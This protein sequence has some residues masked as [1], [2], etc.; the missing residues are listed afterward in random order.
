LRTQLRWHGWPLLVL[1]A[2]TLLALGLTLLLPERVLSAPTGDVAA[3]FLYSRAFGFGEMAQGKLPLW[4]PYLFGGVPF[5]GDFQS[6]LLYPP[7]LT[8]LLLPVGLAISW[9]LAIHLFWMGVSVY[10]WACAGRGLSRR[11]GLVAGIAAM[12]CFPFFLHLHAGHLSNICTMAWAPWIFLAV[13]RWFLSRQWRWVI[14]GAAAA[15]L[16]IYAGHPQYAYYTAIMAG[17]Y[18]LI[19]WPWHR[20]FWSFA[21][22]LLALYPLA[23]LLSAAQLLPGLEATAESIRAMDL[24]VSFARSFSFPPENIFTL[25]TPWLWGGLESAFPYAGRW[26][27]WEMNLFGGLGIFLLALAGLGV[28]SGPL[29][30]SVF[31]GEPAS[32]LGKGSIFASCGIKLAVCWVFALLLALGSNTPL[33]DLLVSLVPGFDAIRGISKFVFFCGLFLALLAGFGAQRLLDRPAAPRVVWV[34]L[35]LALLLGLAS[36]W[37]QTPSFHQMVE[38]WVA[39]WTEEDALRTFF[40]GD[41]TEALLSAVTTTLPRAALALSLWCAGFWLTGLHPR[42]LLLFLL[43][44]CGEIFWAARG[45]VVS[46]P[47]QMQNILTLRESLRRIPGDFRIVNSFD[48]NMAIALQREGIWGQE[49]SVLWRYD[50]LVRTVQRLPVGDPSQPFY[51]RFNHP[52]MEM[53]RAHIVM[54][55]RP[56]G[57]DLVPQGRPFPRFF[58]AREAD[59]LPREEILEELREPFFDLRRKVLLEEEPYPAP[60]GTLRESSVVAT[61]VSTDFLELTASN[62]APAVLVIGDTYARGWRVRAK[63]GSTQIQYQL[64][65]AN[66]ALKAI[67][68]APGIHHLRI[69]YAPASFR[70]GV[71]LTVLTLLALGVIHWARESRKPGGPS[72]PPLPSDPAP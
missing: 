65:P 31:P 16:Q 11:A 37:V 30:N 46:F 69:E 21:P 19:H 50:H 3:Q 42:L 34:G 9:S 36:A 68:L 10:F 61:G 27:I 43:C 63:Q 28:R 49:P 38:A 15:A 20:G 33:H 18:A 23:A 22:G 55:P 17:F 54:K 48:P 64:L 67:P 25:F 14:I 71:W 58:L 57:V 12:F 47:L 24:P 40:P 53:L 29:E 51:Y 8:F 41:R 66:H 13:D 1:A 35:A 72:G 2:L 7:N 52:V 59:V 39:M 5:L 60:D 6:A 56:G 32:L 4:N 26:L 70:L 44:A 45:T 62:D